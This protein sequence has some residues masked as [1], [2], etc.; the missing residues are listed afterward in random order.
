MNGFAMQQTDFPFVASIIDDASTD[1]E[2]DVLLAYLQENFDT[3][4]AETA[5]RR[6][7]DEAVIYLARHKTNSNCYFLLVLLKYNHYSIHK[8]KTHYYAEWLE[9]ADYVA[10]CEGDDY[11]ER[12]DKLR[13]QART[14]DEHPDIGLCYSK[15]RIVEGTE[16][17]DK[18]VGW[19]V[20]KDL[21][22]GNVIPTA[23]IC[24][25]TRFYLEYCHDPDVAR[26]WTNWLMGDYPMSLYTSRFSR[27]Y[28]QDEVT[29]AYR[30]LPESASHFQDVEKEKRF[31][32]NA[33]EIQTFFWTKFSPGDRAL[34]EQI[35][36]QYGLTLMRI[37]IKYGRIREAQKVAWKM[38]VGKKVKLLSCFLAF[39]PVRSY[40]LKLVSQ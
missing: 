19:P 7:T 8:D 18:T 12:A 23:S 25:R 29:C 28:F 16:V 3:G 24:L 32:D 2:Q 27:L 17:T 30:M 13:V 31:F 20:V 5:Y 35:D 39:P 38:K 22:L 11:W 1:G 40:C 6:E 15:A 37:F 10:H 9:C 14:M 33:Y 4:D 26:L 34:R 36:T 21:I